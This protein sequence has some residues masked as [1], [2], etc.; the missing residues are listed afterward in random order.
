MKITTNGTDVTSHDMFV[1]LVA[2]FRGCA[3]ERHAPQP[4]G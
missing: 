3:T 4:P 1:P 2:I